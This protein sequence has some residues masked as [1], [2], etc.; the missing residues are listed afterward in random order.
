MLFFKKIYFCSIILKN[1][2][3]KSKF[4]NMY[5]Y[6]TKLCK[7]INIDLN[8]IKFFVTKIDIKSHIYTVYWFFDII[9]I[10]LQNHTEY[11]IVNIKKIKNNLYYLLLVI[12]IFNFIW[13]TNQPIVRYKF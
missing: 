4:I 2:S 8:N 9:K 7:H 11:I 5:N 1:K 10:I 3:F 13:G 12:K 6:I